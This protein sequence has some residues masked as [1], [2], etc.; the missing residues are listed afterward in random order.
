MVYLFYK[1]QPIYNPQKILLEKPI[2]VENERIIKGN[3][4][5]YGKGQMKILKTKTHIHPVSIQK[6][7]KS[8]KSLHPTQKPIQLLEWL[9]KSY[10][11]ENDTVLDFTMGC[12]STGVAC[13]NTNRKFIGIELNKEYFDIA[14][15]TIKIYK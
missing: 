3:T 9:I 10:S 8:S 5:N 1:K 4:P 15:D 12:G 11:N 2:I 7:S 14:V 6:F 13:V